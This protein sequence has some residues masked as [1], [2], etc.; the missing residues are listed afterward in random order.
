MKLDIGCGVQKKP[1][2]L[3]ID[4]IETAHTDYVFDITKDRFPF[5]DGSVEELYCGDVIEHITY[6]DMIHMMNEAWR[7]LKP[8]GKFTI[9]TVY[10]FKGWTDHPPH[11]RP[12]FEN[13]F[14]Y[15][16]KVDSETI[17]HMRKTDGINCFF[18]VKRTII[19]DGNLTFNLVKE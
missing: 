9:N 13:Q 18:K 2:F 14:E 15:F 10:G 6:Q 5:D 19:K 11:T 16:K 12:I 8:K 3:G 4:K 7:I 1:E 17:N